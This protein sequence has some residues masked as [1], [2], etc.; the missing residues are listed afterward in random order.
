MD[1]NMWRLHL[2]TKACPWFKHLWSRPEIVSLFRHKWKEQL[3]GGFSRLHK[4]Y[5]DPLTETHLFFHSSAMKLCTTYSKF[6]KRSDSLGHKGCPITQN[7]IKKISVRFLTP[8]AKKIVFRWTLLKILKN[9]CCLI[10]FFLVSQQKIYWTQ[11]WEMATL[12]SNS[13]WS[14]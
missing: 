10:K 5:K 1:Q 13:P 4:V 6:L 3:P 8:E 2:E 12:T 14:V 11:G 7:L 9:F